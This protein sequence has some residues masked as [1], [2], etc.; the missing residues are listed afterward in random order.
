[1]HVETHINM[2][3]YMDVHLRLFPGK[4]LEVRM[5]FVLMTFTFPLQPRWCPKAEKLV[6][7]GKADFC[8]AF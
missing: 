3:Y 1:M 2:S 7:A 5:M 4:L 8:E 6:K